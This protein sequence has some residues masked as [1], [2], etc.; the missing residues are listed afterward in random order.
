[1]YSG[2]SCEPKFFTG[3]TAVRFT[4]TGAASVV[5]SESVFLPST[6]L[7]MLMSPLFSASDSVSLNVESLLP[8]VVRLSAVESNTSRM[9]VSCLSA[10]DVVLL[11]SPSALLRLAALALS[12]LEAVLTELPISLSCGLRF[13]SKSECTALIEAFACVARSLMAAW[14]SLESLMPSSICC[15]ASV[16]VA[17]SVFCISMALFSLLMD[18]SNLPMIAVSVFFSKSVSEVSVSSLFCRSSWVFCR[19]S[20]M[21]WYCA[22]WL[23]TLDA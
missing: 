19:S 3:N 11:R 21:C 5:A 12:A 14:L 17:A 2:A 18:A 16:S 7:T 15:A 4:L 20:T 22:V 8:A 9:E 1:M 23:V 13:V 10:L 6:S